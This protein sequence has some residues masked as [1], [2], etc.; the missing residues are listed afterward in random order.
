MLLH[1]F[2]THLF[3]NIIPKIFMSEKYRKNQLTEEKT[4]YVHLYTAHAVR[5]P[6]FGIQIKPLMLYRCRY[7]DPISSWRVVALL[8][9]S[10]FPI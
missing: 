10:T 9:N 7:L 6:N 8:A 1:V 5:R 3:L 2:L 4:T